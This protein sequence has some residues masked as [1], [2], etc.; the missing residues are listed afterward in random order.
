MKNSGGVLQASRKYDALAVLKLAIRKIV[1]GVLMLF[2]VSAI[3]FGLLASAGGDALT[4]LRDNPQV[5]PETIERLRSV[6]GLDRPVAVRYGKWLGDFIRGDMG[7][8][9]TYR[10]PVFSLVLSRLGYTAALGFLALMI[11]ASIASVIAYLTVRYPSAVLDQAADLIVLLTSSTPRIVLSLAALLITVWSADSFFAIKQNSTASFVIASFVLS[12]PLIAIF[13]AQAKS[14]LKTAMSMLF[15]QLARSKGLGEREVI[16]RH[17]L[18]EALNPILTIVGLS[19][20]GLI[21]GSVVV[22]TVLGWPGIG[23]LTVSAVRTRDVSLVMGIVVVAS[24]AV[25]LGNSLAELLQLIND[26]RMLRAETE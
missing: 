2:V 5:S 26:K 6:Y 15:V 20:G 9:F 18:R 22:E 17:G 7:E 16:L 23:A 10:T 3:A 1:Q 14:E 24:V 4:A 25:W 11:A 19:L 21:G 12:V 8:S 13:L